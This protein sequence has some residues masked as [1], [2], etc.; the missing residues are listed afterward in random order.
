MSADEGPMLTPV[1]IRRGPSPR[2]QARWE[3]RGQVGEVE[4]LRSGRLG[5]SVA[6]GLPGTCAVIYSAEL[7][8][9]AFERRS[10]RLTWCAA[11]SPITLWGLQE[12]VSAVGAWLV[13][14]CGMRVLPSG[15]SRQCWRHAAPCRRVCWTSRGLFDRRN[16]AGERF[17]TAVSV[18]FLTAVS[19]NGD[20]G[21][22]QFLLGV[23]AGGYRYYPRR[24]L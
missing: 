10:E 2:P 21:V 11:C 12:D 7:C 3:G 19:E 6:G 4:E 1:G 24:Q 18:F 9:G 20:L 5:F 8:S 13:A 16:P 14:V 23:V 17:L 15:N 22:D